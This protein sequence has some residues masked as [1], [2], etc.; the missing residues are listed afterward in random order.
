MSLC[1]FA[2]SLLSKQM[3]VTLPFL[4]LVL[5]Y[6]PL[7]RV[8]RHT[9]EG[10][11]NEPRES[12]S[13]PYPW[14]RLVLEKTAYFGLSAAFCIV[15]I[16]G[17]Q[18]AGGMPSVTEFPFNT[19]C[20]NAIVAYAIYLS[21]TVWPMDLAVFYP[22]PK[23]DLWAEA[24]AASLLLVFLTAVALKG[25]HQRPYLLV[26]WLWYVGTLVPVIGL[27]LIGIQQTAD[28]YTYFP[29]I[30]LL[31]AVAWLVPSLTP[32]GLW[33]KYVLPGFALVIVIAL[34]VTARVQTTCWRNSITLFTH[35]LAVVDSS[36]AHN[37]LG[38]ALSNRGQFDQAIRHID[39]AIRHWRQAININ[40][41]LWVAHL[42][43]GSL[44]LMQGNRRLA[45]E[46]LQ[47][48]VQLQPDSTAA[49]ELL[50]RA[51]DK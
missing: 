10:L 3:L 23:H 14:K 28:R 32:T 33:R 22:Y 29:M 30:G 44:Y 21:K 4:L 12:P 36:V 7:D 31:I 37:N 5:D 38:V 26:G 42:D 11:A 9:T 45:I 20:L 15:A 27:V 19:R 49:Q 2:L 46:H 51:Q 43:V 34:M 50:R 41:R 40:P 8:K 47:R 35:A 48:A 39:E 16:Y 1:A 18:S 17:Q 24:V 6:W 13:L 25:R